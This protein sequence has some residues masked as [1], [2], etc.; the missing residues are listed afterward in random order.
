MP[1]SDAGMR[2]WWLGGEAVEGGQGGQIG[3]IFE[4]GMTDGMEL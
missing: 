1:S 4:A 3:G 2:G